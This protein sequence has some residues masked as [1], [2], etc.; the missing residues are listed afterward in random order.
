MIFL[1]DPLTR[2]HRIICAGMLHRHREDWLHYHCSSKSPKTPLRMDRRQ[3]LTQTQNALNSLLR[4]CQQASIPLFVQTTRQDHPLRRGSASRIPSKQK[5]LSTF[6]NLISVFFYLLTLSMRLVATLRF[7]P[8]YVRASR[9]ADHAKGGTLCF[10]VS[11]ANPDIV[12]YARPT[13]F[14]PRRAD[15]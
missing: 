11:L 7:E 9:S 12:P 4:P 10:V 3:C 15:I 5:G 1:E 8:A 2:S 13:G 6:P 14:D